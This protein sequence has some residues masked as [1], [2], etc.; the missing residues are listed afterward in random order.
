MFFFWLVFDLLVTCSVLIVWL[1]LLVFFRVV[2]G[3][4]SCWCVCWVL[5]ELGFLLAFVRLLAVLLVCGLGV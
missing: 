2:V 5:F 3:F 4:A 1:G